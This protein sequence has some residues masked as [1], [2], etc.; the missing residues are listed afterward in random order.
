[1]SSDNRQLAPFIHTEKNAPYI[2]MTFL[3]ALVPC[4]VNAM[5]YY[6][7][8]AVVLIVFC[9]ASFVLSDYLCMKPFE[10]LSDSRKVQSDNPLIQELF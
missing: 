5:F 8:R 2:Y 7:V 3:A 1:M 4:V 9:M 10:T 6:G